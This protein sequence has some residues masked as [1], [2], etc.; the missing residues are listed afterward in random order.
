MADEGGI[1]SDSSGLSAHEPFTLDIPNSPGVPILIA[2]PHGGRQYSDALLERMRR[3][4]YSAPRLEDRY[5]DQLAIAVARE[6]SASL[7]VAHAPRAMIDLNRSDEDVDW[8][9][10]AEGAPVEVPKSAANRRSR[11][12]L[13]LVP[14]RLP[15]LGEIWRDRIS[16]AELDARIDTIHRP[17]HRALAQQ[18][19][20]LRDRWGAALLL[21]VHSMPPLGN[22]QVGERG[23]EF[24]IGDRF[25]ASSDAMLSSRALS[26][27]SSEDRLVAHNRPY[28]GG[29]VLDR[30]GMPARG[31][32]ALQ[33][34]V[35]RSSY[36]DAGLSEP[37]AR[38]PAIV[39][40][41][42]GLVRTLA[43]EVCQMGA[44]RD[45]PLAAE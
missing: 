18:L 11:S 3:P 25:G 44:A 45:F 30:H 23:A 39:R 20:Y 43:E 24:V 37:S 36:L 27:L 9:M 14:R 17:Y 7:I 32:H 1:R 16:R 5:V 40:L 15:G 29:Y 19:A 26:Y 34:E 22:R 35:C 10:I 28:S 8:H 12:G 21:D 33:I 4:D 6:T 2:A 42:S 41:L 31:I 13:G 38:M